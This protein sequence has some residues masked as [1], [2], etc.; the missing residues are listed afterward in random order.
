MNNFQ[1]ELLSISKSISELAFQLE[2]LAK[3]INRKSIK[4]NPNRSSTSSK[5]IA[6]IATNENT[7]MLDTVE[8]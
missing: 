2:A 3:G 4:K 8:N 5:K 7:A 6:G 1:K